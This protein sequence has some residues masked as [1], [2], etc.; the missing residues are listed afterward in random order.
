MTTPCELHIYHNSKQFSDKVAK[1]I[2]QSAKVLEKKYNYFD[3]NSYLSKI[4]D[5]TTDIL[6]TETKELLKRAK[7]YYETT[8]GI[9]DI[10][11]ATI[12][13]IYKLDNI[14]KFDIEKAR[15]LQF[16]GCENFEIKRDKIQFSNP[17]TKIDQLAS[18]THS[19]K[20]K[21]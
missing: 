16:V 4:N 19:K 2:L 9:F 14:K 10:T 11:T 8:S 20:K 12:K 13:D 21:T 7:S 18:K 15:L 1:N 3:A 6:D 17:C 5:R